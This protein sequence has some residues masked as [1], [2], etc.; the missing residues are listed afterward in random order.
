MSRNDKKLTVPT[1]GCGELKLEGIKDTNELDIILGSL[2]GGHHWIRLG[3]NGHIEHV[4]SYEKLPK[5][6]KD[7]EMLPFWKKKKVNTQM[8]LS[9]HTVE[10]DDYSQHSF[11]SI[12]IQSLCGNYYTDNG[13]VRQAK[14]LERYGFVCLRSQRGNGGEFWELWFLPSISFA[15][16]SLHK[17]I[18][19]S[20]KNDEKLKTQVAVEF[21]RTHASFGTLDISVQRLAMPSPD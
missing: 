10:P 19:K 15:K 7:K 1:Y 3:E 16:G 5:P 11:P 18:E 14:L 20:N 6:T 8:R 21:L 12:T 4:P 17:A 13:Y 9:D 2:R